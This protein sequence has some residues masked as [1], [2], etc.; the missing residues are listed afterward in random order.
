MGRGR[1][2]GGCDLDRLE[3]VTG[4]QE[5]ISRRWMPHPVVVSFGRIEGGKAFNVIAERV[6]LLGTVRCL[7]SDLHD[8]LPPGS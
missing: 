5:A 2:V 1:I 3:V 4:L 6:T 7:C 8:R